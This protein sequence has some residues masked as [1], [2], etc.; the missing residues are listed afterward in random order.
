VLLV[1]FPSSLMFCMR[2]SVPTAQIIEFGSALGQEA[3]WS[4]TL[5]R[6][7]CAS[8]VGYPAVNS[9]FPVE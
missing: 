7:F 6:A 5:I 1:R 3:A 4:T 9:R 8:C 2:R